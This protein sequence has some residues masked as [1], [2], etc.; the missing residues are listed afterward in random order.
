MEDGG[1]FPNNNWICPD[2]QILLNEREQ[3]KI[4]KTLKS[5]DYVIP[6]YDSLK[7]LIRGRTYKVKEVKFNDHKSSTGYTS[8]TDIKIKLDGSERWYTSWNFRRCTNQETRDIGL[9]EI[10][11]EATNTEKVNKHKRKI[12]YYEDDDKKKLLLEFLVSASNDRFRNQMDIIDWAV[13][14][15]AKQYKLVREDFE[16]VIGLTIEE[17]LQILK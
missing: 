11:D 13:T 9:K 10:F 2:Y 15:S 3:T 6:L 17:F 16:S 1:D 14:K 4:D 12:D 5:G 8:W 7:T